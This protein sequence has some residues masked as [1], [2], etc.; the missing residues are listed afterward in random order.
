MSSQRH[1]TRRGSCAG[2]RARICRF[3]W[4]QA[5]RRRSGTR[6]PAV[7]IGTAAVIL[8]GAAVGAQTPVCG[9]Q[10]VHTYP[11]DAAAYTQGLLYAGGQLFESTGLYG[12]SSLRRVELE[13]GDVL[14]SIDLEPDDF[15][16][17]LALWDGRLI[18]LTWEE[19]TAYVWDAETFASMGSFTYTGQGWGLTHDGRRLI[20]S[21]GSSVLAFRDPETFAELGSIGVVDDGSPV[22]SLNE[23]EWI[24][25]EVFAN[26]YLTD[27]IARIDPDTGE[28]IAW[29]DLTGLLDP[30]PPGTGVL[31][32][33]AWDDDGERLFVTGKLWP[34]LF[35]IELVGCPELRLFFDGFESGGTTGWSTTTP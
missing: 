15:G 5:N 14:Q 3:R 24:R 4:G 10:V 31:N 30:V 26:R 28:V 7:V 27:L 16:E 1:L 17:G 20:M 25:G 34:S 9:Y 23:L 33:I 19:H 35:E 29:I 2:L 12:Q 22:T 32:G 13:N 18:Q 21:N 11:H 8:C 6:R